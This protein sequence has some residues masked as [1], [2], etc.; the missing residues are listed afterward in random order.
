MEHVACCQDG[1]TI[2]VDFHV[3]TED[4]SVATDDFFCFGVPHDEL[5]VAVV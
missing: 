1:L 2:A 3:G 4:I 5:F